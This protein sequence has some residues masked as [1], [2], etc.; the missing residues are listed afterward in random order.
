MTWLPQ[1]GELY[2]ALDNWDLS[3]PPVFKGDTFLVLDARELNNGPNCIIK[4][5]TVR[6]EVSIYASKDDVKEL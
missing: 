2:E 4:V 1:V 6:G 5:M 3:K